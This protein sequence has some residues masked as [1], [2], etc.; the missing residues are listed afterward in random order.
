MYEVSWTVYCQE[1]ELLSPVYIIYKKTKQ[2]IMKKIY[3][4]L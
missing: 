3:I 4:Y 2:I 1:G